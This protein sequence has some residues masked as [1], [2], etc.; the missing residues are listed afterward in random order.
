MLHLLAQIDHAAL[1]LALAGHC[2]LGA[3]ITWLVVQ[4]LG[5]AGRRWRRR[6]GC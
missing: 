2:A 1:L 6:R 5:T 4:H 3:S